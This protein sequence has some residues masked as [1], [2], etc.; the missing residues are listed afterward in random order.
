[1]AD[2]ERERYWRVYAVVLAV[3]VLCAMALIYIV[4]HLADDAERRRDEGYAARGFLAGAPGRADITEPTLTLPAISTVY[5][6]LSRRS[7]V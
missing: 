4:A 5:S 3:V 6:G 1:M 2:E 7:N